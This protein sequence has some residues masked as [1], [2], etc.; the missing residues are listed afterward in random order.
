MHFHSLLKYFLDY[1]TNAE[2]V[3]GYVE[4]QTDS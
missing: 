2:Y 3:I 4:I 1:L